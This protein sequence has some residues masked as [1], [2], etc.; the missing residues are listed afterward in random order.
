MNTLQTL[1]AALQRHPH[2]LLV[3]LAIADALEEEGQEEQE[4]HA[5]LWIAEVASQFRLPT[6]PERRR[7]L[8]RQRVTLPLPEYTNSIGMRFAWIPSGKFM[9]GDSFCDSYYAYCSQTP[10]HEVTLTKAF[11]MEIYEVTQE[12]W[13]QVMG[14]NPSRLRGSR[15]PVE[16]VSWHQAMEFCKRL[17]ELPEEKEKGYTYRLPTEAEWEYACRGGGVE[18]SIY[19]FGNTITSDNAN[20]GR[21]FGETTEVGKYAPN[22][23]GLYDMHGNLFEWC[24]DA[25][26]TYQDRAETDPHGPAE[27]SRRVIRGGSCVHDD[28]ICKSSN[29]LSSSIN[30]TGQYLG[31]RVVCEAQS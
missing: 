12:Q 26:R 17:S 11:H 10:R 30:Y 5:R 1:Q 25:P 27:D 16:Q 3:W 18:F 23:F 15:R 19:H 20:Y 7:E 22:A 4:E 29:R 28:F 21:N 24:L 6:N 9:M 2:D 8:E 31:F 14:S 13:E